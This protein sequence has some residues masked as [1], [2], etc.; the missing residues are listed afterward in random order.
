MEPA[1]PVNFDVAIARN[2]LPVSLTLDP[3]HT[4]PVSVRQGQLLVGQVALDLQSSTRSTAGTLTIERA[5]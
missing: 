5:G 2:R 4:L 3:H 1:Q